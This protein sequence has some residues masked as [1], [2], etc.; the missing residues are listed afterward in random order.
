MEAW[1]RSGLVADIVLACL[2]VEAIGLLAWRRATGRGPTSGGLLALLLPGGF[3]V[4]ALRF[5]LTGAPWWLIPA[6]LAAALGAHLAD[7]RERLRG[8]T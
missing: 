8:P 6:A 1:V 5:A 7:L 2:V 3:L 4:L